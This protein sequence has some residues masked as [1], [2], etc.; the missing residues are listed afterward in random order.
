[1]W[2]SSM[3]LLNYSFTRLLHHIKYICIQRQW[4]H[5][6]DF[7]CIAT[8][9]ELLQRSVPCQCCKTLLRIWHLKAAH[10]RLYNACDWKLV[11]LLA[12]R[13]PYTSLK[14]CWLQA[15]KVLPNF[16]FFFYYWSEGIC[17]CKGKPTFVDKFGESGC[18]RQE[19]KY[20]NIY[21]SFISYDVDY[22]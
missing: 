13:W 19:E 10:L 20:N 2:F 11:F 5:S 14:I 15:S 6:E 4:D 18:S 3:K 17:N 9:K 16:L 7:T 22:I 21:W 1:M 12:A 8:A